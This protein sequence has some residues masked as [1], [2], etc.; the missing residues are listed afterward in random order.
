[1]KAKRHQKGFK[2]ISEY[3]GIMRTSCRVVSCHMISSSSLNCHRLNP[4]AYHIFTKYCDLKHD[5]QIKRFL[6]PPV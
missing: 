5:A 3:V 1:M 6:L 2:L 4:S